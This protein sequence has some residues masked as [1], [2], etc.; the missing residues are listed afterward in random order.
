M[1]KEYIKIVA[2]RILSSLLV[3]F[4]VV[5]FVFLI[6]HISPGNPA[7]KYLS[8]K[9]SSELYKEI[10]DSY[11]L[12]SSL[13]EQYFSFVKNVFSGDLGVSY[14]YREP[15]V[16]VILPYLKFTLIFATLSFLFQIVVS[17]LLVYFVV[18]YNSKRFAKYLSNLN[19]SLYSVPVFI[20]S[21]FLIY[22]FSYQLSLFPSS[23][24]TSFNFSELNIVQKFIDYFR[25]L[26]LP[27]IASSLVGIPIYYKYLLDSVKSNLNKIYI[28]NLK[29]IGVSKKE[30]LFKH[31]F[32]NSINS[33]IAVAGVEYGILLGGSVIVETIFALPGMGR[34]TMSAVIT[35]DYPLI[36]GTVLT[37][38]IIIMLVNLFADLLRVAIDK[39]LFKG[40]LS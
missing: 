38:A 31:V 28:K 39:R 5:S 36:I 8:P 29:V 25:H 6:I 19:L 1:N 40:L 13:V 21:V 20:T 24:L 26:F 17:V 10:S 16:S 11:N 4:L 2:S 7:H 22:F 15:V 27:L 32:P 33:V 37:S 3:L 14:N 30:I 9:L 18:H 35:R 23:G 34:L 12:N